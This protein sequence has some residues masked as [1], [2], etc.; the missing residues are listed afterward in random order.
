MLPEL[1][2]SVDVETAGPVTPTYSLLSI[3]ACL[4]DDPELTFFTEVCPINDRFQPEAMEI[5]GLDFERLKRTAPDPRTA[6][7]AFAEWVIRFAGE[8]F[9][10]V[11]TGLAIAFDWSFLAYYFDTYN[12][13]V[14]P[15][16]RSPVDVKSLYLGN[17]GGTWDSTRSSQI[18]KVLAP[19]LR[20]N[21]HPVVDAQYQAELYRLVRAHQSAR[22]S[23][24]RKD[25]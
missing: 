1:F 3:G 19:S 10:P 20:G 11:M 24:D 14:N 5:N 16:H 22:S 9:Q 18:D 13:G 12:D 17:N 6:M 2:V 8:G 15:F 23:G 25:S 4:C 21:H 7:R